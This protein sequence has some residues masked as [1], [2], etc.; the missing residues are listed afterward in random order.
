MDQ[1]IKTNVGLAQNRAKDWLSN[2][3]NRY[4]TIGFVVLGVVSFFH[5]LFL[6][7]PTGFPIQST[8]KIEEGTTLGQIVDQFKEDKLIRSPFLM[9]AFVVILG[10]DRNVMAGD[11]YMG[12][13]QNVMAIAR[14]V[15]SGAFAFD[16]IAISVPEGATISDMSIIFSRRLPEFD[17]RRFLSIAEDEE[18]YLF[19]DTYFF[20]PNT[21]DVQVVDVMRETFKKRIESI[22]E[23]IEA[24]GKSVEDIIIMA[25]I[26]EKEARRL[27]TKKKISG[28]LWKRISIGMP[29]QVDAV[30]PYI[31]GKN[32]FELTLEDLRNESPYNTYVH[33]GLPPTPIANPGLNS[34]LA[35]VTPIESNYLFYLADRDGITHYSATFEE[36]KRKKRLYLN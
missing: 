34:I 6:S 22:S 17:E 23:E 3:R 1:L 19:P 32:T 11:Y 4:L 5:V 2:D 33:K 16:P 14:R 18:G 29:L 36:H 10:G 24:F 27:Q 21:T 13:K 12:V 15:T 9:K 20:L 7:A 28:I 31:I 26:L 35:A 25:S 8:I 30:F